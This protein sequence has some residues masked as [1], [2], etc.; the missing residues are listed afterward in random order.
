MRWLVLLCTVAAMAEVKNP[1]SDLPNIDEFDQLMQLRFQTGGPAPAAGSFVAGLNHTL[2]PPGS[3]NA[4]GMSR[5]V[6][7]PS[8]GQP[9]LPRFNVTRDFEPEN[10][11]EKDALAALEASPVQVGLYLF[12]RAI[13]NSNV[14]VRNYRALKGPAAVTQGAPRPRW[15]PTGENPAAPPDALP[16]WKAIYPLAQRAMKSFADGGSGFETSL[17]TWNIAVR[18][19]VASQDR[20]IACHNS[21]A[22]GTGGAVVMHQPLGGLIYAYRRAAA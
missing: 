21:N 16:D 7:P 8:F 9:F 4:L 5:M 6:A 17:G 10:D 2:L 12:G 11:A 22:Y 15:Y 18:P 1:A 3:P 20:C 19:V 14:D 13:L